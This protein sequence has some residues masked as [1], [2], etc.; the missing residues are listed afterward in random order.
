MFPKQ[1]F[2]TLDTV[3]VA[4]DV[5][6]SSYFSLSAGLAG[7]F[8]LHPMTIT[9]A[10]RHRAEMKLTE[11]ATEVDEGLEDGQKQADV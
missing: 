11:T 2:E 1:F 8:P 5:I 9:E 6:L 4:Q 7:F 3:S 10:E